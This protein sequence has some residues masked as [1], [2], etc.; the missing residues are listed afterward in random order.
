LDTGQPV[1]GPVAEHDNPL[2]N[3]FMKRIV[4]KAVPLL[5]GLLFLYSGLSKLL[6]PGHAVMALVSFDL[7]LVWADWLVYALVITELYLGAMLVLRIDLRLTL[8]LSMG[9]MF[10][11]VAFMW[12]LSTLANPP[13]CG[14]LGLT[15]IF[16]STRHEAIFGLLRNVTLMVLLKIAYDEHLKAMVRPVTGGS[17]LTPSLNPPEP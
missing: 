1:H 11:F 3:R 17:R 5:V 10:C 4:S 7:P 2:L 15:G 8:S 14:C 6:W 16:E 9:L 12:Y 13:A